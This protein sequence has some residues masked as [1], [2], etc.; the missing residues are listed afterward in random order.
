MVQ[1]EDFD[2][3]TLERDLDGGERAVSECRHCAQVA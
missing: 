1:F 3:F 2:G